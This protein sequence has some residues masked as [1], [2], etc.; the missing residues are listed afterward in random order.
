MEPRKHETSLP[1][2][3]TVGLPRQ[4]RRAAGLLWCAL[5]IAALGIAVG[6]SG[7]KDHGDSMVA[8]G[9]SSAASSTGGSAASD[10][11]A[12][13]GNQGG[14]ADGSAGSLIVNVG[15]SAGSGPSDAGFEACSGSVFK[16]DEAPTP[17]DIYFI[18][19]RTASMGTDCAY[20]HGNTPPV[21]SKACFATYALSDYL[22]NENPIV[23]TR[24][25]FQFMS[26]SKTD[27]DGTLY[28][29][30]LVALTQLPVP[31]ND[32]LI[33]TI[34][35]ETFAGGFGTHI[36]GALR[37]MAQYTSTHVTA[38]R[39]MIGVLMTDGDPSGCEENI[40][41]LSGL[42]S[43]HLATDKIKTYIIGMTGAVDANLE[44]YAVAGGADA[45]ADNCGDVAAPCHYWNVGDGSG[46]AVAAALQGIIKQ[47]VPLPCDYPVAGLTPPTGQSLD[48]GKV[49]VTLTDKDQISTT[50][51]QVADSASCPAAVPAWYY[52]DPA[53]PTS[54]SLCK[55]ACDLVTSSTS[56][57]SVNIVVGCEDTVVVPR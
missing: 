14:T 29:T 23:D 54:I 48:L 5:P 20:V 15:G 19:D 4:R 11:A 16:Q 51:G 30:P 33:T 12:A 38:G 18:F 7:N 1:L 37:G 41:T 28:A 2:I 50:I 56:G 22:I 44:Q 47:A 46:T 55:N 36:E 39:E 35:N 9:G 49:N 24:L 31:Q 52:D 42:I 32:S 34:S 25:A 57:A 43:D 27:C 3:R 6:C 13:S 21:A 53:K 10:G 26:L 8:S 40:T 17:L 45:H